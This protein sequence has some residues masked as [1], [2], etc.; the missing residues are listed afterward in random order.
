MWFGGVRVPYT[1]RGHD[2]DYSAPVLGAS[3]NSPDRSGMGV[4]H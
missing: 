4:A 2:W 1:L 3:P